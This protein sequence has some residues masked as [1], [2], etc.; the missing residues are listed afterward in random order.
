M[1]MPAQGEDAA[2]LKRQRAD[3][4]IALALEG[5]WEEAVSLNRQILETSPNDVDSWNRLGKALLELGRLRES[6]EAYQ[7][8]LE[9]DPVNTIA[10]RNLERLANV[11]EEEFARE[12]TGKAAQDVF[13]E[14]MGKS[15]TSMLQDVQ[16][17]ML[18]R[19]V[20]GD[21]V[22]LKADDT[23][24]RVENAQGEFIGTVEPKLGLRLTRLMQGGN[25]Y[26][27]AI[28][29]VSDAGAEIIIKETYRDPSQTR[30]SFPATSAEGLRPYTRE[31][32][33]RYDIDE[34]EDETEDE[35]EVEDWEADETEVGEP[36]LMSLSSFKETIE[37]HEDEDDEL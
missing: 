28:K 15:G 19:L 27:A 9:L 11:K 30:L 25:R 33:L 7:T 6:R 22:Y 29:S 34:E 23:V 13:I 18:S 4:A 37:G 10:K 12:G 31:T 35:A 3:Q 16:T 1:T 5:R 8:A 20:A 2:R 32:L 14:E 21:E 24:L 17:D 36:G 26:A